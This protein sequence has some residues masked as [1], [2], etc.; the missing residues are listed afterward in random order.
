MVLEMDGI[1][2]EQK[3]WIYMSFIGMKMKL[4]DE[5]DQS[6]G[7]FL[8]G[9]QGKK[10]WTVP[11]SVGFDISFDEFKLESYHLQGTQ[12]T[13]N[14]PPVSFMS[15]QWLVAAPSLHLG[16]RHGFDQNRGCKDGRAHGHHELVFGPCD[17][18]EEHQWPHFRCRI[19]FLK[20]FGKDN[21]E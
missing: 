9:S 13:Q 2:T 12:G 21:H 14:R 20:G 3:T 5:M 18:H 15:C 16:L 10:P 1:T 4:N 11:I 6:R 17:Q 8:I 7:Q 19:W